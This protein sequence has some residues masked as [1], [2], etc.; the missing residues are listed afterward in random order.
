MDQLVCHC[1][2]NHQDTWFVSMSKMTSHHRTIDSLLNIIIPSEILCL[3]LYCFEFAIHIG[4][5]V[6]RNIQDTIFE[7]TTHIISPGFKHDISNDVIFF[8]N[9]ISRKLLQ[10][11]IACKP[12]PHAI[13]MC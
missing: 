2:Y 3:M 7:L 12:K 8:E 1:E 9:T 11:A 6:E 5:N 13:N 10:T 4:V